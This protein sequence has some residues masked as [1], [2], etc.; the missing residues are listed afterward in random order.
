MPQRRA[1]EVLDLADR[2]I[3]M[4]AMVNAHH[5]FYQVLTRVVTPDGTLFPRLKALYPI[6][7]NMG[8]NEIYLSAKLAAAELLLSGCTTSSDHLYILP[9]D[10]TIDDEIRALKEIG[11]RLTA[12]R[13]SM[14][15]GE[16]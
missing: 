10:A 15:I 1:D 6:W 2:H 14:S 16:S 7:A 5:H 11:L 13:G 12:V 9:N 3:V 4:P 8:S